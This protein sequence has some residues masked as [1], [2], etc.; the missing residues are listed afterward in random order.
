[1][2]KEAEGFEELTFAGSNA[3]LIRIGGWSSA[4]CILISLI[5]MMMLGSR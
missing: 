2:N 3:G 1:M 4:V 5:G